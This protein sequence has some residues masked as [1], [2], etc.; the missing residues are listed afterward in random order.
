[1]EKTDQRIRGVRAGE[2]SSDHFSLQELQNAVLTILTKYWLHKYFLHIKDSQMRILNSA[3]VPH[4][5][6]CLVENLKENMQTLN[7]GLKMAQGKSV[8]QPETSQKNEKTEG[9]WTGLFAPQMDVND[10]I[11]MKKDVV[12]FID[13]GEVSVEPA[14]KA[15]VDKTLQKYIDQPQFLESTVLL[16]QKISECS[17]RFKYRL[18]LDKF[19]FIYISSCYINSV[20]SSSTFS[21]R[22][23]S[24]FLQVCQD[25]QMIFQTKY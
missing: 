23:I 10:I 6:W 14:D 20:V 25:E 16:W 8:L 5:S 4:N 19:I 2:D 24:L 12:T 21:T 9:K 18:L 7:I 13:D 3:I 1:M 11:S 17:E 22:Y 15:V